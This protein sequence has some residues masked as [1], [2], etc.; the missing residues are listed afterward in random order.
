VERQPT[1]LVLENDDA[2]LASSALVRAD[3]GWMFATR[4]DGGVL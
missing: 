3:A 2:A 4:G 1:P